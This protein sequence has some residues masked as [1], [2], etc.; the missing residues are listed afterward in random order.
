MAGLGDNHQVLDANAELAGQLHG[1]EDQRAAAYTDALI[2]S[3]SPF[4][5]SA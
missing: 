4:L 3:S 2:L 1:D 5:V